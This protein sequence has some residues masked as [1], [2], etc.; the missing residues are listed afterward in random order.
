LRGLHFGRNE[1]L[2]S[3]GMKK[4]LLTL[5]LVP[6]LA[7]AA[8]VMLGKISELSWGE[9]GAGN[10][11]ASWGSAPVVDVGS[12]VAWYKMTS[13]GTNATQ[14]LDFAGSYNL[15]NMPSVAS[16][17]TLVSTNLPAWYSFAGDD[18][19]F[20]AELATNDFSLSKGGTIS[21]WA[22]HST[23]G[24]GGNVVAYCNGTSASK[25]N[26]IIDQDGYMYFQFRGD[27]Y[28]G[29][30]HYGINTPIVSANW[31]HY[32]ITW[33][34]QPNVSGIHIYTNN[35][36]VTANFTADTVAT[37]TGTQQGNLYVGWLGTSG[38]YF[39]NGLLDDVRIFTN[40]ISGTQRTN[41]YTEGRQ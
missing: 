33:D 15:S 24:N 29:E 8:D 30:A 5:L 7:F 39:Y 6:C 37:Y 19:F 36:E 9:A 12:P 41:I 23:S 2:D 4:L 32:L 11:M 34:G 3:T 26:F 16:G 21:F 14:I 31:W 38:G 10:K 18:Y 1:L 25:W 13:D 27:G 17:P 28:S 40:V 22:L 20:G 35:T